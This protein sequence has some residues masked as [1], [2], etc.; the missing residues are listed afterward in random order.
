MFAVYYCILKWEKYLLGMNFTVWTDHR[1]LLW[2]AKHDSPRVTR[3]RLRL[4]EY[5]FDV[6]HIPGN[7]NVVADAL[8]RLHPPEAPA[9]DASWPGASVTAG[10]VPTA[11]GVASEGPVDDQLVDLIS[12]MY[13]TQS[14]VIQVLTK[15]FDV[16]GVMVM[17][18]ALFPSCAVMLSMFEVIARCARRLL[19]QSFQQ[20]L[21]LG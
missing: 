14:L 8:S 3:W 1:N 17:A 9:P 6:R 11:S 12:R 20:Q 10:P 5:D 13:H 16:F 19:A 2:M 21:V 18:I 4:S 15:W 7:A